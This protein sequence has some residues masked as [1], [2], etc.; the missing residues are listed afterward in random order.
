ME[1]KTN[2]DT[3]ELALNKKYL[4]KPLMTIEEIK[5]SNLVE[6]MDEK[7]K[8]NLEENLQYPLLL[9]HSINGEAVNVR[10]KIVNERLLGIYIEVD[11]EGSLD[12]YYS[13]DGAASEQANDKQIPKIKG[14]NAVEY[15][16]VQE[17][18]KIYG[19]FP[20]EEDFTGTI[21]KLQ[22]KI[23]KITDELIRLNQERSSLE[24][25]NKA[26]QA[27]DSIYKEYELSGFDEDVLNKNLD[28]IGK[29]EK[30]KEK[31]LNTTD[32]K[33][34]A[35]LEERIKTIENE[36]KKLD[37]IKNDISLDSNQISDSYS[38]YQK[39]KDIGTR[40]LE[41]IKKEFICNLKA[42]DEL[43]S[44]IACDKDKITRYFYKE[45]TKVINE[46][47][48]RLNKEIN[49]I[50]I[51]EEG[52][53][54]NIEYLI[55]KLK[56]EERYLK[57][58]HPL[59]DMNKENEIKKIAK[60]A[61]EDI[62]SN[63]DSD[64]NAISELYNI[65][66]RMAQIQRDLKLKKDLVELKKEA[67]L[68]E[69]AK[70]KLDILEKYKPIMVTRNKHKDNE[71]FKNS[72][73]KKYEKEIKEYNQAEDELKSMNISNLDDY[74]KAKIIFDD[75]EQELIEAEN[76]SDI[77]SLDAEKE[78]SK[79]IKYKA[80][81]DDII[82]QNSDILNVNMETYFADEVKVKEDSSKKIQNTINEKE[83]LK[84]DE[85]GINKEN[86]LKEN[87]D[88]VKEESLPKENVNKQQEDNKTVKPADNKNKGKQVKENK[89]NKNKSVKNGQS[90]NNTQKNKPQKKT[91]EQLKKELLCNLKAKDEL[92]SISKN[93]ISEDMKAFCEEKVKKIDEDIKLLDKEI[94][95]L[96]V[97]GKS[98]IDDK[99]NYMKEKFVFVSKMYN[100]IDQER[101]S[102]KYNS[103]K[104]NQIR[105][106][107][108]KAM[109]N[110]DKAIVE[111]FKDISKLHTIENRI[112][113]VQK[114]LDLKQQMIDLE[115]EG[116]KLEEAK[117]KL[118]IVNRYGYMMGFVS[119]TFYVNSYA[120][121]LKSQRE[122]YNQAKGEL[123]ELNISNK[124]D[125]KEVKK[126]YDAKRKRIL[127]DKNIS[128][129]TNL[130]RE[131]ELERIEN[132]RKKQNEIIE[133]Y[134]AV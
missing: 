26:F 34:E 81:R 28:N 29:Y 120:N 23:A 60:S 61:M 33:E 99:I 132:Y 39:Y 116:R 100:P 2:I 82:K 115:E 10:L 16:K 123:S 110:M 52:V 6:I 68:L 76:I 130:D 114:V 83:L 122:A 73:E 11:Y 113:E 27:L 79:I 105:E 41:K 53:D 57:P 24:E 84:K 54:D 71:L 18:C 66:S 98:E 133:K 127:A 51:I 93:T 38:A 128:Q 75:K 129:I 74:D 55:Q 12:G 77:A 8:V 37:Q 32:I 118:N 59:N 124:K 87:K 36:I 58:N 126:A 131:E 109:A 96:G 107:T 106:I 65:E 64:L 45:K 90:K 44:I 22:S 92:K 72:Y 20:S 119:D 9:K 1:T 14:V 104:E 63:M 108:E 121:T 31:V 47:I 112:V 125:F 43:K 134:K 97:L 46:N 89:N 42:K 25:A 88:I 80:K 86:E 56:D 101:Y 70:E 103:L 35:E 117:E 95:S 13:S 17:L 102:R 40:K 85:N 30:I 3:V 78:N 7:S 111:E 62:N 50:S 48:K 21:K 49:A 19:R 5:N 91:L 94:G 69:N 67:Q 4:I 15:K